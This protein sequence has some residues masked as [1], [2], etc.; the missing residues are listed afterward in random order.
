M[1]GMRVRG[2]WP[3][4]VQMRRGWAL[5]VARPW[6]DQTETVAALRLDRGGDRFLGMCADWLADQGVEL[7]RSP[8][9]GEAQTDLWRRAGF[10]DHLELVVFERSLTDPFE[11]PT[12]RVAELASPDIPLLAA[13][14]NRAFEPDWRVGRGGLE[15]AL[16]ATPGSVVLAVTDRDIPLGFAI[17]GEM[18]GVAY[19]QRLAVDPDHAGGGIGSSLVRSGCQWGRGRGAH[20]M[21]LNT[22]PENQAAAGLYLREGFVALGPRLR[23]LARPAPG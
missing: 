18:A 23:V 17:V 20:S 22:Q 13:I 1:S 2:A 21:L 14:D 6:N 4:R 10:S 11:V 19:L 7:I 16:E 9:L 8:A 3:Q 12:R 5:A 15:D